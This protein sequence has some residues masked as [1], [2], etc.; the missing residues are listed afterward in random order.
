M[1]HGEGSGGGTGSTRVQITV[2]DEAELEQRFGEELRAGSLFISQEKPPPA[3]TLVVVDETMA[4]LTLDGPN[5]LPA[6]VFGPAIM[7]GSVGKTLWG[8][9][10]V[11]LACG[12]FLPPLHSRWRSCLLR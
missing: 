7:L 6:A 2:A 11:E 10:R 5:P 1:S 9:I 8:G 4:E 3:G 12:C